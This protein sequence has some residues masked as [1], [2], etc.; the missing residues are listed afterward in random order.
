[1]GS[2]NLTEDTKIEKKVLT[3]IR[4]SNTPQEPKQIVRVVKEDPSAVREALR[5][6]VNSGDLLLTLDWKV[7]VKP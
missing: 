3:A 5:S 4:K 7:R 1:M 6:L 2:T